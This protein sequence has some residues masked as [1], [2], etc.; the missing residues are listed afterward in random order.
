MTPNESGPSHDAALPEKKIGAAMRQ[1]RE[2]HGISLR[3]MARRLNYNSHTTLLNYEQGGAMPTEDAVR[4]YEKVLA[5]EPGSLLQV[6]EQARIARHGD[7]FAKRRAH[8]PAIFVDA[9]GSEPEN[10][11]QPHGKSLRFRRSTMTTVAAVIIAI[12]TT[13]GIFLHQQN[14]NKAAPVEPEVIVADSTDPK[15][16]GCSDDAITTDKL[17][18]YHPAQY[19]VGVLELRTSKRCGTSWGKFTQTA[20]LP[21]SPTLMIEIN[22][23]RPADSA[24]SKFRIKYAGQGVYGNQ[25]FS[26]HQC[27]YAEITI[28]RSGQSSPAIRTKCFRGD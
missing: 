18:V 14:S 24:V 3:G 8:V 1:A 6:L 27:V 11:N 9:H 20:G 25:L 4:G 16:T 15:V 7:P 26:R 22:A 2:V 21:E 5:L 12:A 13:V 23:N 17:D 19:L 10:R 28:S